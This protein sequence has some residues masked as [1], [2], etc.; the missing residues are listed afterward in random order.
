[1]LPIKLWSDICPQNLFD[2]W[3]Y[4]SEIVWNVTMTGWESHGLRSVE[5]NDSEWGEGSFELAVLVV[6]ISS[7]IHSSDDLWLSLFL[8]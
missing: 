8:T 7:N 3:N 6:L 4:P 2:P 1:M 5:A